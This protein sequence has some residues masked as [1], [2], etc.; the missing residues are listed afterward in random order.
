MSKRVLILGAGLVSRPIVDYLLEKS[1]FELTVADLDP[2]N[3]EGVIDGRERARAVALDV[4]DEQGLGELIAASDIVV[5]LLPYTLHPLVAGH[6]LNAGKP[7]V[8]ASYV[9][10][11]LK[12]LDQEAREKSLIFLCEVGLDPGIDHMSA[13]QIIHDIQARGGKVRVFRS[14][15]GGLPE[16]AAADNPFGYKFSWS[17]AGVLMAG[18]NDARFIEN[19]TEVTIPEQGLFKSAWHMEIAGMSFEA[20]PNRDSTPYAAIYGLDD[21]KTLLRGTLRFP[22]WSLIIDELKAMGLTRATPVALRAPFSPRALLEKHQGDLE[23]IRQA[24]PQ[25]VD[26][27]LE[28]LGL[29]DSEPREWSGDTLIDCLA[30]LMSERMGY[31]PDE[32]DMVVLHHEFEAEFDDHQEVIHSTLVDYGQVGG[33]SAMARTVSLPVAIA[34]KLILEG[35]IE[36]TG[37]RIPVDESIYR[38]ILRELEGLGIRFEENKVRQ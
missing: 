2:A 22:G 36:L 5:S 7:M 11:E 13:M 17:P 30:Q 9:S 33:S 12:A 4:N 3:A 29:Y 1:D 28:W 16:P 24:L 18:N 8:N 19:G 23:T 25:R 26:S 35:E 38:P 21:I 27:A 37:V 15:C 6:C 32:R 14:V 31:G 20:Y 10:P 34:V